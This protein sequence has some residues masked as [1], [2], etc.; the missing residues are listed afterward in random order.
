MWSS[1]KRDSAGKYQTEQSQRPDEEDRPA[2]PTTVTVK[3]SGLM[4]LHTI[5]QLTIEDSPLTD[6]NRRH[7]EPNAEVAKNDYTDIS[8]ASAHV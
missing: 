6:S 1:V 4:D 3:A 8:R 7:L 2:R 5:N